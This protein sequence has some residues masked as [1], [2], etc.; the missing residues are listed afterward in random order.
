MNTCCCASACDAD[1]KG[2][3]SILNQQ[4]AT[5]KGEMSLP[6]ALLESIKAHQQQPHI[7]TLTLGMRTDDGR[8]V[9]ISFVHRPLGLDFKKEAPITILKVRPGSPAEEMGMKE[10]WTVVS[11]NKEDIREKNFSYQFAMIRN[12]SRQL[13]GKVD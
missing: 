3:I 11:I 13:P 4:P 9:D 7:P 12:A 8:V 2:D 10:G 5:S 1:K 6:G